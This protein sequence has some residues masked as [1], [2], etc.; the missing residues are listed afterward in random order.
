M[1][2]TFHIVL[3]TLLLSATVPFGAQAQS[4]N[5]L[6]YE[7]L[8]RMELLEQELRQLRGELEVLQYRQR[9]GSDAE[10]ARRVEA[11]ERRLAGEAVTADEP[12]TLS[13]QLLSP[14]PDDVSDTL[15]DPVPTPSPDSV[16][17]PPPPGA[18]E[19]YEQGAALVREGRYAEGSDELRR[20]INIYPANRL[21]PEAYY[22]L[23][24][25]HYAQRQFD[26]AEQ[27]LV[28]LG[29]NYSDHPR[30]PD[31]LLKLGYIYS[32]RGDTDRARQVLE[33]LLNSY[34]DSVAASLGEM[35]LRQ[36]R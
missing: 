10:L 27:A 5:P 3:T 16:N 18:R 20:F 30:I 13:G 21:T 36:L 34:P 22:W 29:S 32:E 17:Q 7:L 35:Q 24:E 11:L 28:T 31:A 15:P 33:R 19:V 4:D 26:Q 23:G 6:L 2:R 9:Q 14:V 12:A 1:A 25:A 8:D